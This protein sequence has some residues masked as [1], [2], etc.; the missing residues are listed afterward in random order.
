[1]IYVY[2]SA[3]EPIRQGDIFRCLPKTE[4]LLGPE[5]LPLILEP[6]E[7]GTHEVDWMQV[8]RS[9]SG[10]PQLTTA[11]V[12]SVTGIVITQDCDALRCENIALCEV[13]RFDAV[14][15]KYNESTRPHK[16]VK[17][18]TQHARVN[19]K[20]YY[21]PPDPKMGFDRMAVDFTSVFEVPRV[22]LAKHR[23]TL[24]LGRL[25]DKVAWP[26]FRERV[27]QFFRRYPYNEWYPFTS[28]EVDLYESGFPTLVKRYP[29]QEKRS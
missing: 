1:M 14:E 20:W 17:I 5:N 9:Q 27:S 11:S 7:D 22:M 2:L 13:R 25:N 21:L 6:T 23:E 12:R 3:S 26:H 28:D 15:G 18:V 16:F 10:K 8:S 29:W 4:L 24:R 19:Q